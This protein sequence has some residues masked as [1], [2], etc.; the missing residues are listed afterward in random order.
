MVSEIGPYERMAVIHVNTPGAADE[1]RIR[2]EHLFP[3][4][5]TTITSDITPAI[6]AHLGPGAI[7]FASIAV[8]G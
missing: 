7:G 8:D 1:L 2:A 5:K 6:G 4:D 3:K